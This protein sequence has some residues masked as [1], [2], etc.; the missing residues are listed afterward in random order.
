MFFLYLLCFGSF[1]KFCVK[2]S[3]HLLFPWGCIT[4][5]S[6]ILVPST[7]SR[8]SNFIESRDADIHA[9]DILLKLLC[10]VLLFIYLF[11]H[12]IDCLI[13]T[14]LAPKFREDKI[15]TKCRED[16]KEVPKIGVLSRLTLYTTTAVTLIYF[17]SAG[18]GFSKVKT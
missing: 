11:M 15:F 9:S 13:Q 6:V 4:V 2:F 12:S 3:V 1:Y 8:K 5:V 14:E 16:K 7:L 18:I 17:M 10:M